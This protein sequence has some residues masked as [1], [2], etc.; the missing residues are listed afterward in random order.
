M[1]GKNTNKKKIK[2][3]GHDPGF[4]RTWLRIE[5]NWYYQ[6]PRRYKT[7]AILFMVG[8]LVLIA[9]MILLIILENAGVIPM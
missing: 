6:D 4:F 1:P 2:L 8:F 9:I 3:N 7:N 5:K